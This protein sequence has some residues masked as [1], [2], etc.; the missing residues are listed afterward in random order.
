MS[1]IDFI[2]IKLTNR[3]TC[4]VYTILTFTRTIMIKIIAML[5]FVLTSFRRFITFLWHYDTFTKIIMKLYTMMKNKYVNCFKWIYINKVFK[6]LYLKLFS[7][8]KIIQTP[9]KKCSPWLLFCFK[10]T[11]TKMGIVIYKIRYKMFLDP[12]S[13]ICQ[14]WSWWKHIQIFYCVNMIHTI[15]SYSTSGTC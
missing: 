2:K 3:C 15:Q 14:Q 1:I 10:R 4:G 12:F 7:S 9:N 11:S 5:P 13:F 6:Y 8:T